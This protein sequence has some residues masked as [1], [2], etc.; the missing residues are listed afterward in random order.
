MKSDKHAKK[1]HKKQK[2]KSAPGANIDQWSSD[3][4]AGTEL[5][6]AQQ[7]PDAMPGSSKEDGSDSDQEAAEAAAADS[8]PA[9]A[10]T[11]TQS[12]KELKKRSRMAQKRKSKH[13]QH[14]EDDQKGGKHRKLAAKQ[15]PVAQAKVSSWTSDD[16]DGE[17]NP[18]PDNRSAASQL[19]SDR[20]GSRHAADDGV[21]N[22]AKKGIAR[23]RKA[24]TASVHAAQEMVEKR[25]DGASA[26]GAAGDEVHSPTQQATSP[27]PRLAQHAKHRSRLRKARASPEQPQQQPTAADDDIMV[28]LE[29][30]LPEME[31]DQQAKSAKDGAE[32]NAKLRQQELDPEASAGGARKYREEKRKVGSGKHH[33]ASRSAD[34]EEDEAMLEDKHG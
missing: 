28:D 33:S 20:Q 14:G 1:R 19:E 17:L 3:D 27:V 18:P 29:D 26:E 9:R 2:Q 6:S 8:S 24:E 12:D 34:Q 13:G 25:N 4:S 23:K 11:G 22:K 10:A 32:T 31:L 21:D 30:D 16:S 7:Q 15:T 5:A